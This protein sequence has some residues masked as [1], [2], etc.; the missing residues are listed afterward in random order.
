MKRDDDL[1]DFGGLLLRYHFLI[2]FGSLW[3]FHH[4]FFWQ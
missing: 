1:V 3:I 4:P 2:L